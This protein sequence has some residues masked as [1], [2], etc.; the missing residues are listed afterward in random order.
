VAPAVRSN[1][2]S[3]PSVSSWI[4]PAG[5]L[6]G[7][8]ASRR[9]AGDGPF[10]SR[11]RADAVR[12]AR[13]GAATAEPGAEAS[14]SCI[15]KPHRRRSRSSRTRRPIGRKRTRVPAA[16]PPR[17]GCGVEASIGNRSCQ[18]VRV[19]IASSCRGRGARHEP[20][21][22]ARAGSRCDLIERFDLEALSDAAEGYRTLRLRV[23][24]DPRLLVERTAYL[25]VFRSLALR[26][27]PAGGPHR[28][29]V[30]RA[31]RLA[32]LA[33]RRSPRQRASI[34]RRMGRRRT[35]I[36]DRRPR[37][38]PP[39]GADLHR[40]PAADASSSSRSPYVLHDGR[41]VAPHPRVKVL[42]A[43]SGWCS[44]PVPAMPDLHGRRARGG[45]L[46]ANYAVRR[47]HVLDQL[48]RRRTSS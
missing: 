22:G 46:P 8:R 26:W 28:P 2:G 39:A 9:R 33:P 3:R 10:R 11:S 12:C 24:G 20:P 32:S 21:T 6:T 48:L 47:P 30:R 4:R 38:G 13:Q 14:A 31:G 45:E 16:P 15:G 27:T 23:R 18:S 41:G 37:A 36:A 5:R 40:V 1:D 44:T 19:E 35:G 34:G 17:A 42:P 43:E 7:E 25:P 29:A